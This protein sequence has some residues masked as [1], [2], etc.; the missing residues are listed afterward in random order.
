[1][2]HPFHNDVRR[3]QRNK[4]RQG[5]C[6]V[7]VSAQGLSKHFRFETRG[8]HTSKCGFAAFIC[9]IFSTRVVSVVMNVRPIVLV[10]GFAGSR[11]ITRRNVK[12]PQTGRPKNDFINLNIFDRHWKN[13]FELKM[14]PKTSSLDICDDIE[15]HDFGGVEG[16]RN[17]CD[18]CQSIDRVIA[19]T[20]GT[21]NTIDKMYNYRY[22]D[23]FIL[24]LEASG[25]H[26][27]IN[28]FGAP[29]DFRKIGLRDYL[30]IY[31]SRFKMLLESSYAINGK[32]AV[33][34]AHSI[35]ALVVYILLTEYLEPF[36]KR[37][38]VDRFVSVSAPYGGCSVAVK[39]SLSGYPKLSFLK[40]KYLS[41][42]QRSTGMSLA[43]PNEFGYT[44]SDV[45]L[46]GL[47]PTLQT[48]NVHNYQDVMPS[49]ITDIWK[50]NIAAFTPSYLKNTGVATAIVIASLEKPTDRGYVYKNLGHT[51]NIE[52]LSTRCVAGDA[53]IPRES[54][55][56]HQKRG[57]DFPNY[58]FH[59]FSDSEHTDILCDQRFLD[60]VIEFSRQRT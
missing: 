53:L 14:D 17:L 6:D 41:V 40:D 59:Q 8:T 47:S 13:M 38:Y 35:G 36:W 16:I 3:K 7:I 51:A 44:A 5:V 25:Y 10:P 34:V 49:A 26:P 28:M 18:D 23:K 37:K 46:Q 20:I 42:M 27:R 52:P 9:I 19:K 29:Y 48:Y 32:G 33:I 24:Q 54:L 50:D 55:I 11:L 1:M 58:T 30:E 21:N 45:I 4:N 56:L 43:F 57:A 31:V 60:M 12:H 2:V 15:V 39:T 22:F